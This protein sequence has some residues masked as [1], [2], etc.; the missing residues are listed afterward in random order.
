MKVVEVEIFPS[1]IPANRS[2]H[3][4][5]FSMNTNEY[6]EVVD[7]VFTWTLE[8]ISKQVEKF[9]ACKAV[10]SA[11]FSINLPEQII[12]KEFAFEAFLY[13]LEQAKLPVSIINVE[14]AEKAYLQYKNSVDSFLARIHE[15]GVRIVIDQ[16]G[17]EYESI[18]RLIQNGI[19]A[20]KFDRC[21]ATSIE[22]NRKLENLLKT[23]IHA[24][25]MKGI[26]VLVEG[27]QSKQHDSI[28]ASMGVKKMQGDY[29][30]KPEPPDKLLDDLNA[31]A[32]SKTIHN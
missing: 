7:Q 26:E 6:T 3:P 23:R 32:N 4:Q 12:R 9:R 10:E 27:I 18:S 8:D 17:M 22:H 13:Q 30:F 20:V 15:L 21:F 11:K 29:I 16:Y 24:L 28:F 31:L 25:Q 14:V 2:D 1:F 19:G 5:Q